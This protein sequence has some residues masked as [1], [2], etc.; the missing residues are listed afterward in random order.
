MFLDFV[1]VFDGVSILA[2]SEYNGFFMLLYNVTMYE[3]SNNVLMLGFVWHPNE[4]NR[5][6]RLE[7]H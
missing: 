2:P 3:K 6:L 4:C 1:Y 5:Q 7:L